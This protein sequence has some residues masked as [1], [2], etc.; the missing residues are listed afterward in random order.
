MTAAPDKIWVL[1]KPDGPAEVFTKDCP[2]IP[3][4]LRDDVCYVR[5]DNAE[6]IRRDTLQDVLHDLRR[7]TVDDAEP[8][9][10]DRSGVWLLA[11]ET[12]TKAVERMINDEL[13]NRGR[14]PK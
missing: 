11:L 3:P 9:P 1:W 8:W 12:C 4:E 6:S 14:R 10:E 7:V 13:D 5:A 2:R